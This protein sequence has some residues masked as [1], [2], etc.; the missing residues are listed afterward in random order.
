MDTYTTVST[1]ALPSKW[2]LLPGSRGGDRGSE[3][4][5]NLPG[6]TQPGEDRKVQDLDRVSPH[7]ASK[8]LSAATKLPLSLNTAICKTAS[9]Q[10]HPSSNRPSDYVLLGNQRSRD[11]Q[12]K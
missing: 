3:W 12:N 1:L 11:T 6:D 4:L 7:A 5:H 10:S 9:F 2:V 8:H